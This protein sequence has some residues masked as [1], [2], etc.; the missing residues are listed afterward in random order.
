MLAEFD[1]SVH[2]HGAR[3]DQ[4]L[5]PSPRKR[6]AFR[7][8]RIEPQ[9]GNN[10]RSGTVIIRWG[11]FQAFN[12]PYLHIVF[13][14]PGEIVNEVFPD[15][16][17]RDE[18]GFIPGD[19]VAQDFAGDAGGQRRAEDVGMPQGAGEVISKMMILKSGSISKPGGWMIALLLSS[20]G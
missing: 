7:K 11:R 1:L 13:P 9:A 14:N 15:F 18:T 20:P 8:H 5:G 17:R 19:D 2:F 6:Q 12:L 3:S 4:F 16:R 10:N